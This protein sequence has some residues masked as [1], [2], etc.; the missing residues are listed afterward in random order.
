ME[1]QLGALIEQ[2]KKEGVAAAESE[3]K[4]IVDKANADAE[5][6]VAEARAEAE[7]LL[8]SAKSENERLVRSSEEA[9]R[10]AGR[11]LL[12][13]FRESVARELRAI[14]EKTVDDAYSSEALGALVLRAIE[15]F[16]AN[17]EAESLCAVLN[18]KDL[19]A[20]ESGMLAALRERMLTGVTLRAGDGFDGGFRIAVGESGAYYDFSA[21]AVT[22]MLSAYLA[23]R[24]AALL[25]EAK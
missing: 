19:A 5:A 13:S 14:V 17:A 25:K 18:E 2:I 16:A 8:A 21:E 15:A 24:V 9:I 12:L 23:P 10:Q 1:V 6:I 20:L 22:E 3:A 4:A 11:N 7:R